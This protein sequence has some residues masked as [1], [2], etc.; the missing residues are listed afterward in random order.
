MVIA[1]F[2][3]SSSVISEE[4]V[5]ALLTE[6]VVSIINAKRIFETFIGYV[7]GL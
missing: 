4:G 7:F 5:C 1:Y 3:R 2:F 6:I